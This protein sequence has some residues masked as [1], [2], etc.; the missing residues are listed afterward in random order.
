MQPEYPNIDKG[1]VFQAPG[2]NP[3]AHRGIFANYLTEPPRDPAVVSVR[4]P[5]PWAPRLGCGDLV[6]NRMQRTVVWFLLSALILVAVASAHN[7]EHVERLSDN[8]DPRFLGNC[9][10][11]NG[12][13]AYLGP[14]DAG[15]GTASSMVLDSTSP[16]KHEPL[17]WSQRSKNGT[18]RLV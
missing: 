5:T 14:S 1:A 8:L 2:E 9:P 12:Q 16:A 17:Y 10:T 15:R 7:P 11:E 6:E 3:A 4:S 18:N 13:L